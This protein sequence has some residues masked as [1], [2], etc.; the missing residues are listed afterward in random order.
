MAILIK[1]IELD[2]TDAC[3]MK[4]KHCYKNS[5][6]KN[7]NLSIESIIN[8]LNMLGEH[9]NIKN[10]VLSGG[11][12]LLYPDLYE[13]LSI[14]NGKCNVRLNSNGILLDKHINFLKK[15]VKFKLQISLDGYDSSTYYMIRQSD[16][17]DR[18]L[19]NAILCKKA[20]IN[21]EFRATLGK[22]YINEYQKFIDVSKECGIPLKFKPIVGLDNVELECVSIQELQNWYSELISK[23]LGLYA[24][25]NLF[26]SHYSCP[27]IRDDPV[28]SALYIDEMGDM[29]PCLGLIS[30]NFCVGNIYT[31]DYCTLEKNI[32]EKREFI[33]KMLAVPK[34]K[35]CENR[36]KI[37]DGSCVAACYY[38]K[39][40]C[41]NNMIGELK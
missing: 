8:F 24:E 38:G 23:K 39:R 21:V 7:T 31:I 41:I 10:I 9:Q 19:S 2:V 18:V 30:N 27:I 26:N 33:K 15:M 29:H 35:E 12:T 36:K 11:E 13:L 40:T 16:M 14:L 37:G 34:C 25:G 4:C 17:F 32:Y 5:N 22:D 1:Y 20:G 28:I 3:N 6:R